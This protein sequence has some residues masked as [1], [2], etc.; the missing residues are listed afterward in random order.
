[1]KIIFHSRTG[2]IRRFIQ[3]SGLQEKAQKLEEN[4]LVN[5]PYLLITYTDKIGE[6]PSKVSQFLE[7]NAEHLVGVASSGNKNFGNQFARSADVISNM[8]QVP[9]VCKFELA[10]NEN[11]FL[12]VRGWVVNYESKH[13]N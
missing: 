12:K 10:G 3:K 6:V 9:I 4:L 11:D 1:M 13:V 5:E 8:Y 7:K 2:N